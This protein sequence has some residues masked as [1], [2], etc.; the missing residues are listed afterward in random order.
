MLTLR[1]KLFFLIVF[2]TIFSEIPHILQLNFLGSFFGKDLS[3]YPILIAF[4]YCI[5]EYR[6]EKQ[7]FQATNMTKIFVAYIIVYVVT[8]FISFVQGLYI[9]PYYDAI[10][11]GPVQQ[12]DKLPMAQ[13]FLQRLGIF[14][15]EQTLLKVWMFARP[16]KGFIFEC[17]WFFSV[18]LMIYLWFRKDAHTGIIILHKAVICASVVVCFYGILDVFYLSGSTVAENILIHVNPFVHN[19]KSNGTWWPPLLWK[20]QL[21]SLFAEPSYYGIFAAFAMPWIWYSLLRAEEWKKKVFVC[22]LFFVFLSGL[23]L[24]KARTANA[25]FFG[26]LTLLVIATIWY[27]KKYFTQNTAVIVILTLF[28]FS[29]A[30]FSMSYMPGSPSR[31]KVMGYSKEKTEAMGVYLQDNLGSITSST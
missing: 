1:N 30:T 31:T 27:R 6:K 18:P 14:I 19:I 8:I 29:I 24:T 16:I 4:I 23:F 13:S 10:L 15:S 17:F 5:W 20:G 22:L 9:Y 21:R 11:A 25:L 3:I 12:I 28:S 2:F 26:E 7:S